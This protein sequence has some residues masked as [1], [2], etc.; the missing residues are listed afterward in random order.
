LL[1][2][3]VGLPITGSIPPAVPAGVACCRGA[4]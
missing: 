1:E 4:G 3:L 2:R